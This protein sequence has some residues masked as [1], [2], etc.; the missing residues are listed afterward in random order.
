[1]NN[2]MDLNLHNEIKV[3]KELEIQINKN[4]NGFQNLVEGIIDKGADYAI[5]SFP[6]NDHVKDI[7]IDVKNSFK[8]KDFKEILKTAINSSIREGIEIINMPINVLKDINK[9]KESAFRGRTYFCY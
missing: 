5:K 3:D 6:I 2:I 8:S 7:L 4:K 9:V 1:M